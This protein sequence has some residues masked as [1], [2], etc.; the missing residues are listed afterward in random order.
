MTT[1]DTTI[2][3]TIATTEMCI[4]SLNYKHFIN[5]INPE[6][7]EI[8]GEPNILSSVLKD[9]FIWFSVKVLNKMNGK[10]N[11]TFILLRGNSVAILVII[12]NKGKEYILITEQLRAPTGSNRFESVAGMMDNDNNP[13]IVATKEIEEETGIVVTEKDFNE[14]GSYYTSPGI[15]EEEMFCFYVLREMND[16]QF[17]E[18]TDKL[19]GTGDD[20][21][22]RLHLI[23]ATWNKVLETKDGKLIASFAM[24]ENMKFHIV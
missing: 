15:T 23:P 21:V 19:Y 16:N 7:M 3:T 2:D 10:V 8:V 24:Y 4:N 20:E 5:S 14:L 9:K 12:V 13:R 17:K 22:I 11:P 1:I 6:H 18:L